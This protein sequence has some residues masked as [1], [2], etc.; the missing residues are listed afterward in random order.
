MTEQPE[1]TLPDRLPMEVLV[2]DRISPESW[3]SLPFGV[4]SD[5]ARASLDL[6]VKPHAMF[7][8]RAGSGKT[9]AMYAL[10]VSALARGFQVVATEPSHCDYESVRPWLSGYGRTMDEIDA[11][12]GRLCCEVRRRERLLEAHDVARWHDLADEVRAAEDVVPVLVLASEIGVAVAHECVPRGLPAEDGWATQVRSDNA[13]AD[14]IALKTARLIQQSHAGI[15]VVIEAQRPE[16][17]RRFPAVVNGIGTLI[18]CGQ[19]A[20]IASTL[21]WGRFDAVRGEQA[22]AIA[23]GLPNRRDYGAPMVMARRDSAPQAVRVAFGGW[24]EAARLLVAL[25]VPHAT[26]SLR[27]MCR[28]YVLAR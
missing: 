22:R 12:L 16:V 11:E 7:I 1:T 2:P 27:P 24:H 20:H 23:A 15:F 14:R 18:E 8:G 25:G 17:M 10:A 4:R 3:R 9:G 26:R 28:S 5:G 13:T 6:A 21:I 19:S